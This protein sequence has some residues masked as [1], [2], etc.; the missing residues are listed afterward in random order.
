MHKK[1][2]D[3]PKQNQNTPAKT[4]TSTKA[5]MKNVGKHFGKQLMLKESWEQLCGFCGFLIYYGLFLS[6]EG[7][8][9]FS[10]FL[11]LCF[12]K[13]IVLFSFSVEGAGN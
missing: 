2:L 5:P 11:F 4:T 12:I 10:R 6:Q 13:L 8:F 3:K 1:H 7:F 9:L